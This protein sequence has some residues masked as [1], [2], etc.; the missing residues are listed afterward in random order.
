MQV[1]RVSDKRNSSRL[2]S[3]N[4]LA[5]TDR[6]W[7]LAVTLVVKHLT[8]GMYSNGIIDKRFDERFG[9]LHCKHFVCYE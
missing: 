3:T 9:C 8:E 6:H 4:P 7:P 2:S 5:V 1:M